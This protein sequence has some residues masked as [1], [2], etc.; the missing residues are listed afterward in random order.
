MKKANGVTTVTFANEFYELPEGFYMEGDL[1]ITKKLLGSDGKAKK[2]DEVFY[3]GIF[4][5]KAHTVLS[6]QVSQNIVELALN[7]AS[8]VS[9][10]V[11]A[12]ITKG[13]ALTLYVTEVDENGKPV[14]GS[15]DFEYTVT[16]DKT[17]VT[18]DE[19]HLE[20]SVTITNREQEAETESETETA[21]SVKTGDDTNLTLYLT[22]LMVSVL[23]MIFLLVF[24]KR[25]GEV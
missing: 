12:A 24:R 13:S 9:E 10:T 25:R 4:A 5:D 20:A 21:K 11:Q 2:S 22:L 6:D 1:T 3:A 8:E 18:V 16:V 7:G 23:L 19:S 15:A 14:A 17:S